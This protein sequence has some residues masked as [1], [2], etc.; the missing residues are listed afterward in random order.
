MFSL[1][2]T[3]NSKCAVWSV[4]ALTVLLFS[5]CVGCAL[6]VGSDG[7]QASSTQE[8]T[9]GRVESAASGAS[10]SSTCTDSGEEADTSATSEAESL[11]E[12]AVGDT[13]NLGPISF[14]AYNAGKRLEQ[15]KDYS[16][17]VL[18]VKGNRVLLVSEGVID[19][20]AYNEEY[21]DVSWESSTIRQW[22][23]ND[24]YGSLPADVQERVVEADV[25]NGGNPQY[26]ATVG[27]TTRD[28]IFLLSLDEA[29]LYFS[30]NEAREAPLDIT[31]DSENTGIWRW[32]LRTPG[33]SAACAALVGGPILYDDRGGTECYSDGIIFSE[34]EGVNRFN[35]IRPAFWLER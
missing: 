34:G 8:N 7:A 5:P 19:R 3:R 9:S 31:G 26:D 27:N 11:Q 25:A 4:A 33:S 15:R 35:G 29:T 21:A 20:R 16:W 23:N 18:A 14:T 32:W 13:I 28:R 17:I 2:K 22:L 10:A 12:A 6:S 24:F 1:D 30:D